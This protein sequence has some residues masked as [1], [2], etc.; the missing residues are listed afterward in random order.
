MIGFFLK[1]LN[2]IYLTKRTPDFHLKIIPQIP[3]VLQQNFIFPL[4]SYSDLYFPIASD[5]NFWL[6]A[7]VLLI[8]LL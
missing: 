2:K 6:S 4:C 8:T 1:H 3:R 5:G 7:M